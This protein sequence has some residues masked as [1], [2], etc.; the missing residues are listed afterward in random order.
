[1]A[2]HLFYIMTLFFIFSTWPKEFQRHARVIHVDRPSSFNRPWM[3]LGKT[4]TESLQALIRLLE[5]S[6]V[7]K[8]ILK[9]ASR[10]AS[11]WGMTLE[12]VLLAGEGS[13]TDT[14][15]V[16]KFSPSRPDKVVYETRSKVY[17]NKGLS[18]KNALLDMA[19]ELTHFSYRR[20]FN[21][22]RNEFS[23]KKFVA[24][25]IE[26]HGGEVDAYLV[27]CK[28]LLEVFGRES[29][30]QSNCSK[31]M[32]EK[33][34]FS[35]NLGIEEFY[36]LGRYYKRFNHVLEKHRVQPESFSGLSSRKSLFISSAY[37]VPYPLAAA[38]E[39]ENIMTRVCHNDQKRLSLMKQQVSRAVASAVQVKQKSLYQSLYQSF[40][41][42]CENVLP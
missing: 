9:R 21:P 29:V 22:Y 11:E 13:L 16:R 33:G 38:Q 34:K 28:V 4:E 5:K 6:N 39:F 18:V 7:G 14:T 25:T 12:D 27:E 31:V 15:L 10:K 17:I 3:K 35:K 8:H 24:S 32:N 23:L 36:K 2:K 20:P 30:H 40:Q 26:G 1:M 37:G 41:D 19:H 42:R